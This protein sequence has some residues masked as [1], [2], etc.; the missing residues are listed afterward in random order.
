MERKLFVIKTF[1][2]RCEC[3]WVPQ[4][5]QSPGSQPHL[6]CPPILKLETREEGLHSETDNNHLLHCE[7]A[8]FTL[9]GIDATVL[10]MLDEC[11]QK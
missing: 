2:K 6:V 7:D 11:S 1:A 4:H 10:Q 9:D 5:H 3:T 8:L